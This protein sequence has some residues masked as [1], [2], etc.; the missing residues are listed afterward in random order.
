MFSGLIVLK[1]ASQKH[2]TDDD[3]DD[4]D[5]D[6]CVSAA[7][8]IGSGFDIFIGSSVSINDLLVFDAFNR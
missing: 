2:R 8:A 4:D 3:D 1:I 7:N 5:D 6:S